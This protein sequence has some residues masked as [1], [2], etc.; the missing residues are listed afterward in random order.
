[1]WSNTYSASKG[2]LA[3]FMSRSFA[4]YWAEGM[5]SMS[6]L[7]SGFSASNCLTNSCTVST[8]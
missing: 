1:M 6:T 5:T 2:V 8:W 7:T 4:A 3:F